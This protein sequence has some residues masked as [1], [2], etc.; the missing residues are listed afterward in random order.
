MRS[1]DENGTMFCSAK[2]GFITHA[3]GDDLKNFNISMK[4]DRVIGL[5]APSNMSHNNSHFPV[6]GRR[7][8]LPFLVLE[9]KKEGDVPGF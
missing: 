1:D 7:I 5:L 9:A 6:I 8:L 4:P 3:L 2:D